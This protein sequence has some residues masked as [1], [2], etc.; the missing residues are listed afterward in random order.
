VYA[1]ARQTVSSRLEIVI[2]CPSENSLGL[3]EAEV[4]G[5]HSVRVIGLGEIKT[6]SAARVA[7]I[8]EASASVVALCEDHAFQS[9]LGGGF[10][11]LINNLGRCRSAINT[12]VS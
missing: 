5:F 11:Q 7:G 4:A 9:G 6:T 1:L 8:C 10:I 12:Q 2:V 3:V